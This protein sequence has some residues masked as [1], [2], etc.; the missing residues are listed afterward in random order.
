M[1]DQRT[2]LTPPADNPECVLFR[3][4]VLA[5]GPECQSQMVVCSKSFKD[6]KALQ[7]HMAAKG[8]EDLGTGGASGTKKASK[9]PIEI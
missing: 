3:L 8:R 6:S 4:Q 7:T 1:D 5:V 2:S 9:I